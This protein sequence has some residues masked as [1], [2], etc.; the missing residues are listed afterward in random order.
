MDPRIHLVPINAVDGSFLD[1]LGLCLEERFLLGAVI[2]R[3][4]EVP[5]S[6]LNQARRQLFLPTLTA[7]VL[8]A[9]HGAAGPLLC[10][11]RFDLYKTSRRFIFGDAD[12]RQGVAVVSVHRL[13]SEFYG[14]PG[15]ANGLF[16][17]TLKECVHELGHVFG[18]RHCYNVRC[19]MYYSTS[20]FETDNQMPHFCEA[21]ERRR[22]R[23]AN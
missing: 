16:Q 6:L 3:P 18:L 19:A 5:T 2:E 12:E 4:L 21:C 13:R 15:D 14:E 7:K 1:R 8:R 17:R 9:F 22:S 20:V 23:A 11:T 10:I